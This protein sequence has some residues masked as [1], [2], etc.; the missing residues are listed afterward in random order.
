MI[1]EL[2]ALLNIKMDSSSGFL[3]KLD[4]LT[5]ILKKN[6]I[7]VEPV[8]GADDYRRKFD[9]LDNAKQNIEKLLEGD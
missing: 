8:S 3:S 4:L 9:S 2:M 5:D 6:K 1:D 7:I